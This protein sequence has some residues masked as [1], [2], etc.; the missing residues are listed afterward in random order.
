MRT[1]DILVA[2]A[3]IVLLALFC[4]YLVYDSSEPSDDG[5]VIIHTNDTHCYY[6]DDGNL[7][8]STVKALK[9]KYESE[10]KVVFTMD[11]GDFLQGNSYGTLTEGY[12]SVLVMNEVGYDVG[13][14][15]NHEFDFTF[16]VMMERISELNYPIICS[17]LVYKSTGESV[18]PEYIVLEKNGVRLGCF[19]ILTPDTPVTTKKGNMGDSMVTD[20]IEASKRMVAKLKGMDVDCIVAIGHIGTMK[21]KYIYSDD[22]CSQV[23][24]IDIFID[25]HSHTEMEDGKISDGSRELKPSN[26]VIASTG[27]HNKNVGVI[28]VDRDGAI[29]A[30]LHHEAM[31][32]RKVETVVNEVHLIIDNMLSEKVGHTEVYLDG[33][34][35]HVR[36]YETNLADLATDSMRWYTDSQVAFV[37]GGGIR[38]SIQQG[39]ITLK[40]VYDVMPF[41]DDLVTMTVTGQ[42]LY[43]VMELSYKRTGEMSGSLIQVSGITVH[44]DTSKDPMS[45]VVSITID[46]EE[47]DLD[48]TYTVCTIDFLANGGNGMTAFEDYPMQLAG[49]E[50]QAF[51]EYLKYIGNI[52]EDTIQGGRLV[53]VQA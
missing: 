39:D 16:P 15:G 17:N 6:G 53:P 41:Q 51:T 1:R 24:G 26:T 4:S 20:P 13:I 47:V 38:A 52:T 37:N 28:T 21:S 49:D 36:V 31:S 25:G 22:I 32:D 7:G 10:G 46:G 5:F 34:R 11:A 2:S 27:C 43:D 18:F 8:F 9:D 50:A 19:G 29:S 30:K 48:A 40:D 44:Y 35:S 12:A 42:T 3:V 14:P 33:E 45:K 23:E